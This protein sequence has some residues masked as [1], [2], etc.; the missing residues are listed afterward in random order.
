MYMCLAADPVIIVTCN[1]GM[2]VLWSLGRVC[3]QNN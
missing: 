1:D 3:E 2:A